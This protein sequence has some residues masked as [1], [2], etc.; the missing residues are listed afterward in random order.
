MKCGTTASLLLLSNSLK[1]FVTAFL[2]GMVTFSIPFIG[3]KF[4]ICYLLD[5]TKGWSDWPVH[6]PI[7]VQE[8]I[9]SQGFQFRK[10]F[11]LQ[12]QSC[13]NKFS[14]FSKLKLF[15]LGLFRHFLIVWNFSNSLWMLSLASHEPR[16]ELKWSA[17]PWFGAIPSELYLLGKCPEPSRKIIF[18]IIVSDWFPSMACDWQH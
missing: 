10:S 2:D 5:S 13:S 4:I 18:W 12:L 14:I 3:M 16:P 11:L 15:D 7:S 17:N 9:S 1:V 8:F 6:Q